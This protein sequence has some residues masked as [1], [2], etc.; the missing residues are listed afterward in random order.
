MWVVRG[1]TYFGRI[2]LSIRVPSQPTSEDFPARP[3]CSPEFVVA[4]G[5]YGGVDC[6]LGALAERAGVVM[7]Y[8]HGLE[9]ICL[10]GEPAKV[11]ESS[12]CWCVRFIRTLCASDS[13]VSGPLFFR[14]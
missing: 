6:W 8:G 9:L 2:V 5:T 14:R 3:C 10:L 11:Q 13:G 4:A 1:T 7:A 12:G